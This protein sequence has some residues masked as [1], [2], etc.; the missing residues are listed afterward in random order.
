MSENFSGHF[1]IAKTALQDPNFDRGIVLIC[2]HDDEGAF[3]LVVN[4]PSPLP[5][6]AA[7]PPLAGL[8]GGS[9][10]LMTGGPCEEERI[11]LLHRSE[12]IAGTLAAPGVY[13]GDDLECVEQIQTL[14]ASG[15]CP[16]FRCF[17]GYAGWAP[18][19]LEFEFHQQA[20]LLAPAQGKHIF[21]T[22][23]HLI[24]AEVLRDMGGEYRLMAET[25]RNPDLN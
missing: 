9:E 19:Q 20:W 21:E 4:R 18:G 16:E 11:F 22:P 3:G 7:M 23:S 17:G 13:L 14:N 25:P 6:I 10:F 5:L 2:R 1:L 15:L 8:D 24:W 12:Q